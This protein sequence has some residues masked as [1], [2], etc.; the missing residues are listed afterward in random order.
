MIL[1]P[2]WEKAKERGFTLLPFVL[3]LT[4]ATETP[5]A[6]TPSP[7]PK[8]YEVQS[9]EI[10]SSGRIYRFRGINVSQ[11]LKKPPFTLGIGAEDFRL[12]RSM[13]MNAI[14]L[15]LSYRAV[16]PEPGKYDEGYLEW[17][18]SMLDLAH[19]FELKVLLDM[20]QDLYGGPFLPH[21]N[22]TWSCP[23]SAQVSPQL[24]TPWFLNYLN[25]I[26]GECFARFFS[27]P[28]RIEKFIAMWVRVALRVGEHP[29]VLGFELLNEPFPGTLSPLDFDEEILAQWIE[30]VGGALS[31]VAPSKLIAFEPSVLGT[32]IGFPSRMRPLRLPRPLYAPHLYLVETEG[33]LPY[34]NRGEEYFVTFLDLKRKEAERHNA[35][36]WIGEWGNVMAWGDEDPE[37]ARNLIAD[38]LAAADELGISSTYW[39]YKPGLFTPTGKLRAFATALIRPTLEWFSGKVTKFRYEEERSTLRFHWSAQPGDSLG[40]ALPTGW[41]FSLD[42]DLPLRFERNS[43]TSLILTYTGSS[44]A[45]FEV[46]LR[47]APNPE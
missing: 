33:G 3:L 36:L 17:L 47:F 16:E 29:A 41:D 10:V 34:P 25:P 5:P 27:D 40:I 24:L 39:E 32:S 4:C 21:G 6:G 1:S 28:E 14:R 15:L 37:R 45:T 19:D 18:G 46:S 20:H 38:F 8:G 12:I 2:L 11:V 44:G 23:E 31:R 13:G 43:D 35:P 7:Y 22:P 26:V 42:P 30:K 9:G